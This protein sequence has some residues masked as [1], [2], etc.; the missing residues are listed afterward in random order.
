MLQSMI[1]LDS[2]VAVAKWISDMWDNVFLRYCLDSGQN[3][4]TSCV[5]TI[6]SCCSVPLQV[7]PHKIT[8]RDL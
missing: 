1:E 4:A 8:E 3:V 2:P 5:L 6:S 7:L